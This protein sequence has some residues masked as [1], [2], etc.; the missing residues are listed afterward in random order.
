MQ[1]EE[2]EIFS[3]LLRRIADALGNI[4][5]SLLFVGVCIVL[6]SCSAH[7]QIRIPVSIIRAEGPHALSEGD[8]YRAFFG[9]RERYRELGFELKLRRFINTVDSKPQVSITTFDFA[10]RLSYWRLEVAKNRWSRPHWITFVMLPP[11]P[12]DGKLWFAGLATTTCQRGSSI[13]IGN[14]SLTNAEGLP[15]FEN[16][17]VILQHELGH[18]LGAGHYDGSYNVMHSLANHLFL[19]EGEYP[20]WA[21]P[22]VGQIYFCRERQSLAATDEGGEPCELTD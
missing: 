15:R 17:Q 9:V 16:S 8:A 11:V 14:A 13:A 3:G 7:A 10:D 1:I 12:F 20:P 18:L 5:I 19:H 4:A 2:L 6:H 22:S 21:I